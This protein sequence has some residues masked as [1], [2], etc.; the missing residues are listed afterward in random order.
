[1]ATNGAWGGLQV[2]VSVPEIQQV[3]NSVNAVFDVIITALDIALTV[4]N[5]IKSFVSSI[6]NPVR[7]IIQQLIQALQNVILDFRKAGIYANGDWYLLGDTTR[8]QLLGGYQGYQSRMITRLTDRRDLNRPT[9]TPSTS[10]VALFLYVGVNVSF[11]NN[12]A[13]TS[14][15]NL[16][17]QLIAGFAQF[18]GFS[19]QASPLPIPAGL[20]SQYAGGT[21][22]LPPGG[23]PPS[24]VATFRSTVSRLMGRTSTIL[25][26]SLAPSPGSGPTLAS[27]VVPPDGFLIEVSVFPQGLYAGYLAPTPGSTGGPD[28][29]PPEGTTDTP[30]SYTTGLYQEADTGRPLQIFGGNDSVL[31]S[32]EVDWTRSFDASGNLN[33]GARPAFFL[34]SLDS[35]QPIH[36]NVF[37]PDPGGSDA[38]RVF[39]QR[40]F[41]VSHEE[42]IAQS[43]VGGT[44]SYELTADDLPWQTPIL[45]DGTPDFAHAVKATTVYV[46]ILSVSDKVKGKDKFKWNVIPF[47]TAQSAQILP[48]PIGTT[49]LGVADRSYPSTVLPVTFPP[50][51]GDLYIQALNT[52]LAVMV[53]SRSDLILPSETLDPTL[54]E[55]FEQTV[56]IPVTEEE[57][58]RRSTFVATNL[59]SFAQNLLPIFGTPRDYFSAPANPMSFGN[60]LRTKVGVLADTIIETQG[61]LPTSLLTTQATLFNRLATWTWSQTDVEG[62]S[63]NASFNVTI[64]QS[65]KGIDEEGA[66]LD[67]YVAKNTNCLS[68]FETAPADSA[69]LATRLGVIPSYVQ[70]P[71]GFGWAIAEIPNSREESPVIVNGSQ[72]QAY[73]ARK[74]FTSQVYEDA[75]RVLGLAVHEST[76][77]GGWIAFRPFASVG[78]LSGLQDVAAVIQNFLE[79]VAAGIQGGEDLILNFISMLEQR[80]REIQEIIRRI[81]S[82]LAIPLSIEIPDALGLFLVANGTDGVISG[83]TSSTNQ[84]TDGAQV[85]AGGLVILAGGV[86]ALI[87]DLI[88]LL[89]NS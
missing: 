64:L 70:L 65:L 35:T 2:R 87:T 18:L 26:W 61:N 43:L 20:R 28:G 3:V 74:L 78:N 16:I 30:S 19:I 23:S 29:V 84:P 12:L 42:V 63:G 38:T 49:T 32:A 46:R 15:F 51:Q 86:P 17:N 89:V 41:Y 25:Q 9:F 48:A 68:G 8:D 57:V 52:A 4:L 31:L 34:T 7:A 82:Y 67:M 72:T 66:R 83:L 39:N 60:D 24:A 6:L 76:A 77:A 21:T 54:V 44:Y 79:S 85:H 88:S 11:V 62:A 27:P 50:P 33:P 10:V 13:D 47:D 55:R 36:S 53:L 71:N 22:R 59:E 80:V 73:Y 69:A 1:M 56:T 75:A 5:I 40:T 81:R 58:P 45:E 14:R 37:G